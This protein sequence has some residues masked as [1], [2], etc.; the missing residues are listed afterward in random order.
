MRDEL[1]QSL[2]LLPC[3]S[4][5]WVRISKP[6]ECSVKKLIRRRRLPASALSVK[7][8]AKNEFR[9]TIMFS[10]HSSEPMV[11]ERGLPDAR[12]G[13]DG[14][15]IDLRLL[16]S[17]V[18]KSDVVLSTKNLASCNGQSGHRNFRRSQSCRRLASSDTRSGRG[19][20]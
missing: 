7:G 19:A 10:S 17:S 2:T 11:N 9:R 3:R 1:C 4:E 14:N 13:H 6:S 8:P 16:P 15:D 12:P 18:Q 5:P 20:S